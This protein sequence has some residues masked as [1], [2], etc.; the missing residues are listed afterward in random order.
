MAD[1]GLMTIEELAGLAGAPTS[2]VRM[3][4]SRGLLPPPT[5]RGR[6]G[7]YGPG[8]LARLRL[9]AQLQ[10]QG[11]SLASIKRVVD[12]WESGRGLEDIMGLEA[13]VAT[14]WGPEEPLRLA[15][16]EFAARF[17]GHEVS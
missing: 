2:T 16:D 4:Q 11:F 17:L 10:E 6:V 1:E 14:A 8:H 9:I 13:Q 3:Y 15:A 7:F 5:R 12:V